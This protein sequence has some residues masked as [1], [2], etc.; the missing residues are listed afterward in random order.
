MRLYLLRHAS[1]D[2]RY[3]GRYNGHIDI[4][5]SDAGHE[6]AAQAAAKLQDMSFD[7]V[8]CSDLA[9]C[10]QTLEYIRAANTVFDERLREK[11]WGRAE[12]MSYDEI[13]RK[14]GITYESFEQF[15]D[16][17][18]GESIAEFAAR[19]GEFFD[20][21]RGKEHANAI[22]VTHGGVIKMLLAKHRKLSLEEAFA[23]DIHYASITII[24]D[25]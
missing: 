19:V 17:V 13:C 24:E 14:F 9:R 12:G 20:E 5:L 3:A 4:S 1:V 8:Y 15:I 21:L 18:G 23:L 2:E 10:R 16:A 11:S 22:V 6:E 7:G 25:F